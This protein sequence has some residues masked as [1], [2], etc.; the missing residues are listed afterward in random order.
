M[1]QYVIDSY[2]QAGKIASQVKKFAKSIIKPEVK[3][4]DIA[5]LIEKKILEL[6]GNLAFP[7][8]LSIGDVA[9]HFSPLYDYDGK[10]PN[11]GVLKVDLG[12][13]VNGYIAD[14]AFS[15]DLSGE[16]EDLVNASK[17]AVERALEIIKPGIKISQIGEIIEKT[18]LRYG[19]KPI[20]NL[21]GHQLDRYKLHAGISIPNTSGFF[22]IK[23]KLP[24][25]SAFAIE[26]FATNGVGYVVDNELATIYS[27]NALSDKKIKSL[28]EHL[29]TFYNVIYSKNRELPFNERNF[30]E[31]IEPTVFRIRIGELLE[32]R[33]AIKY[34]V[35]IEASGS[36]V[37]QFEESVLVLEKESIVYTQ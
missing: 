30:V 24:E 2:L 32:R 8:N 5:N 34:P 4:V 21:T 29:A 14:T 16:H 1:D 20:R 25:N 36:Q 18:I 19:F 11:F 10:I 23:G 37:A 9:A 13:H 33:V 26:P 17:E 6:G 35:L 7:C 15:I 22:N 12:V 27:L 3:L 28:P 31:H